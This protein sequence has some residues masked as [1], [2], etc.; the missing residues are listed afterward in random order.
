MNEPCVIL[1]NQINIRKAIA[2]ET[3]IELAQRIF[4]IAGYEDYTNVHWKSTW[5]V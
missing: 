4:P 2:S 5:N 3:K 1:H